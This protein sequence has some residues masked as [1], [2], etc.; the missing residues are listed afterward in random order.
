MPT[1][2]LTNRWPDELVDRRLEFLIAAARF[3]PPVVVNGELVANHPDPS[4][5]TDTRAILAAVDLAFATNRTALG[6]ELM[7]QA[8]DAMIEQDALTI[9]AIPGTVVGRVRTILVPSGFVIT[10]TN[11]PRM[12]DVPAQPNSPTANDLFADLAIASLFPR[13]GSEGSDESVE[14]SPLFGFGVGEPLLQAAGALLRLPKS[15]PPEYGV[16]ANTAL[17]ADRLVRFQADSAHWERIRVRGTL[18]DLRRLVFEM[19]LRRRGGEFRPFP[20]PSVRVGLAPDIDD[21]VRRLAAEILERYPW[22]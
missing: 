15:S 12:A 21:F 17:W 13:V 11:S 6:L 8:V 10:A 16:M 4:A 7:R 9:A 20:T 14:Q 3:V 2:P 22:L 5:I 19:A 1:L 18:V